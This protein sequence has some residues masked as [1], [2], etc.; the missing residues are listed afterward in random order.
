MTTTSTQPTSIASREVVE[1]PLDERRRPEDRRV[2]LD[3][4]RGPAAAPRAPPRRR[5]SPRSVLPPGCFSTI[6]SRPGPSLMTASPIGGGKPISHVGHVAQPQRRA[7]AEARRSSARGPRASR[8]GERCRTASRWLGVSTKPPAGDGRG[9]GHRL[10]DRVERHAVGPQPVGIDQHLELPV[11]LAPDGDVRDAG[12]RHQPRAGSSTGPASVS[13]ICESVFDDTPIFSTRLV[14]ESGDRITGGL[15][16]RPA[17][18]A[19]R[20]PAAPAPAAA[21]AIRSVPSSKISTT[22]DSP[23][24]D[25]E[26]IVFSPGVPLSAF[27]SGTLTRL[28]TSSVERPGA[29][30]WISTS[31]GA[32]SGK[33]SS[34]A[35]PRRPDADDHEHDRQRQHEHAEP[36]RGGDE[37]VHHGGRSSGIARVRDARPGWRA[38]KTLSHD[39]YS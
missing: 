12:D 5:A 36:Q 29:S 2:D 19:P 1:R 15:R 8:C 24:T 25:F 3:A 34:G 32:N 7:A 9:V 30:V 26:R 28:S 21:R 17:A 16:R 11:A 35:C 27:S 18:A 39:Q 33:T 37:P 31:G 38:L 4:R 13:S 10:D 14:D 23:S 6:S 22:D 20:P